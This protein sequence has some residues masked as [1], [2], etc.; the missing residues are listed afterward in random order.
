M[1]NELIGTKTVIKKNKENEM[2]CSRQGFNIDEVVGYVEVINGV[3]Y[4]NVKGNSL[5]MEDYHGWEFDSSAE[6]QFTKGTKVKLMDAPI[7]KMICESI[8]RLDLIG[9]EGQIEYLTH[10]DIRHGYYVVGAKEI[11]YMKD[12]P[13]WEFI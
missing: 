9:F 4:V 1:N 13:R 10:E 11:I 8:E 12:F 2:L 3:L 7:N 5:R 6:R